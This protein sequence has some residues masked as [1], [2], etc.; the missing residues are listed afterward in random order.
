MSN[1]SVYDTALTFSK[2]KFPDV[3]MTIWSAIAVF[4]K[5][6]ACVA[7]GLCYVH[8][9]AVHGDLKG[10]NVNLTGD[11]LHCMIGDMENQ[12]LLQDEGIFP[13]EQPVSNED[14]LLHISPELVSHY[15]SFLDQGLLTGMGRILIG[16]LGTTDQ[17]RLSEIGRAT[18]IWSFGCLALELEAKC[19]T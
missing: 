4:E 6:N 15:F 14:T 10:K 18:D 17:M 1:A 3:A 16:S 5:A 13:T 12:H 19:R 2:I 9:L 7:G 11:R 8:Q